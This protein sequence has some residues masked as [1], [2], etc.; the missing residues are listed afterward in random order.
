MEARNRMTHRLPTWIRRS[1]WRTYGALALLGALGVVAAGAFALLRTPSWYAPPNIAMDQRQRVRNNLVEAEQRFTESLR[2]NQPFV[3]QLH[4]EDLNRW[5]AMR[6]EIYPLLESLTPSEL[7]EPF[8]VF[9]EGEVT[10]AGRYKLGGVDVVVSLDLAVGFRDGAIEVRALATRC[11]SARVSFDT[12]RLGLDRG[13]DYSAGKLW[14]GSPRIKGDF[15]SGL[16]IDAEGW[17][18]NGGIAYRVTDL[19]VEPG[20]ISISVQPLG[21]RPPPR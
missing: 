5:I 7:V 14:P 11:G 10:V 9:D 4:A 12:S 16:R 6:R 17:W 18:K 15:V 8:V 21:R 1:A 13:V 2:A 20:Q 19:A 3:Y